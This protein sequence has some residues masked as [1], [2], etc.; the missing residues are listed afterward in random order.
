MKSY[1]FC[2]VGEQEMTAFLEGR[3]KP[4]ARRK[5][6][7]HTEQ[8]SICREELRIW[9]EMEQMTAP[10]PGPYFKRDFE[11]ML[12]RESRRGAETARGGR[13]QWLAWAVAAALA[14]GGYV[15][16][17]FN[18]ARERQPEVAELRAEVKTMRTMM[19]MSMLQ[20]Q[21]AVERLRGVSYSVAL[22]NPDREVVEA[23][24]ETLRGDSSVDVRLAAVDALRK[25]TQ[26]PEVRKALSAA[27]PV[28][29]SP[30]VQLEL[31][32]TLVDLKDKP[33]TPELRRMVNREDVDPTVKTRLVKAI[34]EL[35]EQ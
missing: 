10:R 32:E 21:S 22:E 30:L 17:N 15:L 3:L 20:Q 4:E 27:L 6:V 9:A 23:L 8:C 24:V 28:Q 31:I 14:V 33:A 11:A 1:E 25:Y 18:A 29:D 5:F 12:E 35:K 34:E 16:G 26:R 13:P 2:P 7:E 19:A